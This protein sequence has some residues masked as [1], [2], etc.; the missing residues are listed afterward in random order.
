MNTNKN[1]AVAFLLS[2]TT[3]V[4]GKDGPTKENVAAWVNDSEIY[5]SEVSE[6]MQP[7]IEHLKQ[8]YSGHIN[9]ALLKKIRSKVMDTLVQ[10]KAL[11]TSDKA[12]ALAITDEM[13]E[14]QLEENIKKEAFGSLPRYKAYVASK[15][16]SWEAWKIKIKESMVL[17]RIKE[18]FSLKVSPSKEHEL[19]KTYT[20][21][22]ERFYS[23]G[24]VKMS[25]IVLDPESEHTTGKV[26][27]YA[28]GVQN[29]LY[30][31]GPSAWANCV[32]KYSVGPNA[33]KGGQWDWIKL[34]ELPLGFAKT[35]HGMR[36]GEMKKIAHGDYFYFLRLDEF[37]K[38]VQ[39]SF[40][41]AKEQ[42]KKA[43]I[44]DKVA[45]AWNTWAAKEKKKARIKVQ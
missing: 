5:E 11:L 45:K 32:A 28:L 14:K 23:G 21:Q 13:V 43:V 31:A 2:L 36:Q 6:K 20:N 35:I 1:M 44:Q 18:Q 41:E 10:R 42:L 8:K 25:L 33:D 12:K 26:K 9:D 34:S 30:D 7:I 3:L 22:K 38:Q 37:E 39:L 24:R 15:N 29:S 19:K 40:A 27:D 16:L 4:Y 17:S